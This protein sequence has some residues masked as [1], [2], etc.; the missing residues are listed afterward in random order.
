MPV[1]LRFMTNLFSCWD[2]FDCFLT[3]VPRGC[4]V[5]SGCCCLLETVPTDGSEERLDIAGLVVGKLVD[6]GAGGEGP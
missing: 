5:S 6:R 2:H 3:E 4:G 1:P